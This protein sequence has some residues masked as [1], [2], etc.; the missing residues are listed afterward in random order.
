MKFLT[1]SLRMV[2]TTVFRRYD[3]VPRSRKQ[4]DEIEKLF[5][6]ARIVKEVGTTV[7]QSGKNQ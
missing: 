1:E 2:E 6:R 7:Q 5:V 3:L 4:F